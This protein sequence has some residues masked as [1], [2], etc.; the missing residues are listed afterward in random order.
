M[1]HDFIFDTVPMMPAWAIALVALVL[2]ALLVHGSLVLLRKKLPPR[3]VVILGLLRLAIIGV[4]VLCLLQPVV[5]FSRTER[6]WPDALILIDTSQSMGH[7]SSALPGR[8]RL[9]EV[10]ERLRSS[11]LLDELAARHDVRWFAFDRSAS[12][13]EPIDLDGLSPDGE[14]TDFAGSLEAAFEYRRQSDPAAPAPSRALL[15]SDGNDLGTGDVVEVARRLGMQVDT[16]APAA[17]AAETVADTIA[18]ASVQTP[19]RVL[20]GS[21]AHLTMTVRGGG[22]IGRP[23]PVVLMQGDQVLASHELPLVAGQ[24]EQQLRLSFTPG[25]IGLQQYELRLG[26]A[27]AATAPGANVRYAFSVQ[28]VGER[29]EVLVL[30][31][32]W[33]WGFKFLRRVL[34]D[35]PSFTMTAFLPRGEAFMQFGEPERRVNL[36]SFPQTQAELEWFDIIVLGDVNPQRW[37]RG[38]AQAIERLVTD[39]GKSLIV[40]AGPNLARWPDSPELTTLLPVELVRQSAQPIEGPVPVRVTREGAATSFFSLAP[41]T[42]GSTLPALDQVYPP[43]RKKPAATILL[44][45]ANK[46]NA[47]GGIIVAAEHT[48]GRGRVLFLGSDTLWRWQMLGPQ[49]EG[50]LTPHMLFWQQALRAMTPA[51]PAG[52]RVTLSLEP[53]RTRYEAGELV[54]LEAHLTSTRP[55]T[56]P[57]LVSTVTMPDGRQVPLAFSPSGTRSGAFQAEFEASDPGQY[58]IVAAVASEGKPQAEVLTAIDV[59]QPRTESVA[60]TV[61]AENL[62]RI[63]AATAGS[64]IDLADRTTWPTDRQTDLRTVDVRR[65]IHLWNNFSLVLV[66]CTLLALD[67]LLRLLRGYV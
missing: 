18:I 15:V 26:D 49:D 5:S 19:R 58:R 23:V 22:D 33:R 54:F 67:W 1:P 62:A 17:A 25:E 27:D 36:G 6:R 13:L 31:D 66:L 8:P 56:R 12:P 61:D 28:V 29:N 50:G 42:G 9:R 40:V 65:S 38:L 7:E 24:R 37:P 63:A 43:L 10:I 20:L 44:E 59:E 30:E 16:L 2:L 41:V 32:S 14:W 11:G 47:Y 51:R 52:G 4:F 64:S 3:W 53:Q 48:V 46:A 57:T 35:D 60:V 21:N 39:E 45:A 34:E 55:L